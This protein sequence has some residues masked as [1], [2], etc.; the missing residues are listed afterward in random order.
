M[1]VRLDGGRRDR[2]AGEKGVSTKHL[3]SV[4]YSGFGKSSVQHWEYGSLL[5]DV[6]LDSFPQWC[7]FTRRTHVVPARG[8]YVD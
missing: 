7:V 8:A 1:N 6:L 4:R 5:C 2:K 3:L